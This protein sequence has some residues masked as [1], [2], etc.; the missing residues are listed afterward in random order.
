MYVYTQHKKKKKK[1]PGIF[2]VFAFLYI[3]FFQTWLDLFFQFFNFG[4]WSCTKMQ[5]LRTFQESSA[6]IFFGTLEGNLF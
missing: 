2:L 6:S 1:F 5:R 4:K 3:T